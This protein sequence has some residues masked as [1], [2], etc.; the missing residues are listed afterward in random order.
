MLSGRAGLRAMGVLRAFLLAVAAGA[1][2]FALRPALPAVD[3]RPLADSM[4]RTAQQVRLLTDAVLLY[5]HR[6]Q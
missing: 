5:M 3:V 1:R 2:L 4:Q 6:L